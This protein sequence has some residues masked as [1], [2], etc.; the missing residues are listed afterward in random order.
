MKVIGVIP[1]RFESTRFPGKPLAKILNKPMIQWVYE[2][3]KKSKTLDSLIVATDSQLIYNQAKDFGAKVVLT[4]KEHQSGTSR[5]AEVV[6]PLDVEIVV[7]IQGDEPL[8]SHQAIDEAVNTLITDPNIYMATLKQKITE[9]SELSNPN[10]VKVV[11]DKDGFALYFSRSLIPFVS[12]P[13]TSYI[14]KHIGL[15]AYRKDFLL[16]LVHL[17]TTNLEQT[18]KLEQL[19]VLENGYKIKVIKTSYSSIGVDTKEDLEKVSKILMQQENLV[20]H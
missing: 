2:R 20:H 17:P 19:R 1:A 16:K 6:K 18:E 11:T 5:V 4:S 3:A 14:Y 12:P 7:N 9:E 15:Y 10:V 8:I 13:Y